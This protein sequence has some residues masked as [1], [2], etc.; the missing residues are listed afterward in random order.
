DIALAKLDARSTHIIDERKVEI[1]GNDLSV[2]SNPLRHP[3]RHGAVAATDFQHPGIAADSERLN[4]A[5]VHHRSFRSRNFGF[6]G[7]LNTYEKLRQ[8][9]LFSSRRDDLRDWVRG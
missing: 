2:G 3:R 7:R 9:S 1:Q 6:G 8:N 4:V 5:S